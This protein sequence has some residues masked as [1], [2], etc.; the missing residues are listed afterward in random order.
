MIAKEKCSIQDS[1]R[2]N[3]REHGERGA[4]AQSKYF[5][6]KHAAAPKAGKVGNDIEP[7][8]LHAVMAVC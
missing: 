4:D 3:R 2:L 6:E 8:R 5:F 7:R 1:F